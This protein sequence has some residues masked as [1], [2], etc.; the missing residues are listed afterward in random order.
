MSWIFCR[1]LRMEIDLGSLSL[2][3]PLLPEGYRWLSWSPPLLERHS[4]VKWRSFQGEVDGVVF[5][6]LAELKGCRMLMEYITRHEQFVPET[7]WLLVR[8]LPDSSDV[9]DCGTI[10]GLALTEEAGAIQNVGIAHE[11]RGLGLGRAL[12]EKALRGF[13]DIGRRQVGLEVTAENAAAVRLYLAVG[14]R[15]T[16][17]LF[18]EVG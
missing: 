12:V 14:F 15:L 5:R 18:R 3:E 4:A 16:K 7:T 2:Q 13:R 8:D 1:R 6:S 9:V 17:T 11:H 10:Q